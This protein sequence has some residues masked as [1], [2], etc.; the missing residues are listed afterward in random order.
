MF[1]GIIIGR[2]SVVVFQI[3]IIESFLRWKWFTADFLLWDGQNCHYDL[4]TCIDNG[5]IVCRA[6]RTYCNSCVPSVCFSFQ[7]VLCLYCHHG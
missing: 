6:V 2:G 7:C 5:H 1:D 4:H 3:G